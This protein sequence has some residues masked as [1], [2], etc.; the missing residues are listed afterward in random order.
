MRGGGCRK[1]EGIKEGHAWKVRGGTERG[2]ERKWQR[3]NRLSRAEQLRAGGA[4]QDERVEEAARETERVKEG[5]GR[6]RNSSRK[7]QKGRG[8]KIKPLTQA[9]QLGAGG[10]LRNERV[11]EAAGR[12]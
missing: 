4:L 1:K 10:A 7:V 2:Q 3:L 9:E 8:K 12:S 11:E 6:K 5:P